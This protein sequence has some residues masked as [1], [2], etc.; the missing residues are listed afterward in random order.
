MVTAIGF[1]Q[2]FE[3][4]VLELSEAIGKAQEIVHE[5][6]GLVA[7]HP[8]EKDCYTACQKAFTEAESSLRMEV[9]AAPVVVQHAVK[10]KDDAHEIS[11]IGDDIAASSVLRDEPHEKGDEP[12]PRQSQKRPFDDITQRTTI[13]AHA[14]SDFR[15]RQHQTQAER[16]VTDT[17]PEDASRV[18]R[19]ELRERGPRP[20][21]N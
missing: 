2:P 16:G 9:S 11:S 6:P 13:L 5:A 10:Y 14:D 8:A 17:V 20:K 7:L 3:I 12:Q 18:R 21:Y 15:K 19:Y 1:P 4:V